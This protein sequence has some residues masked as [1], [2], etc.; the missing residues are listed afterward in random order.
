MGWRCCRSCWLCLTSYAWIECACKERLYPAYDY[1]GDDDVTREVPERIDHRVAKERMVE[2]F[3]LN[4]R[5]RVYR[6]M[7]PFSMLN[8]SPLV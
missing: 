1:L 7:H 2:L 3:N 4:M 6:V 5:V 8:V